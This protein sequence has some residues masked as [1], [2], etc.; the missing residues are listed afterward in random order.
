MERVMVNKARC[1]KCSS[2]IES[3]YRWDYV[4]CSCGAISI[5]GGRDYYVRRC[6]DLEAIEDLSL[7]ES[8]TY[9]K[10]RKEFTWG[11]RGI[12]GERTF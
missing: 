1:L 2:V 12:D 7:T 10:L 3:I 6:G 4:T 9:E 11:T 5:D 8:S